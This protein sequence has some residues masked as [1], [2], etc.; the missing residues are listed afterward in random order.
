MANLYS[1][2]VVLC[3]ILFRLYVPSKP[4]G[5][6]LNRPNC[7]SKTMTIPLI[8]Y[9]GGAKSFLQKSQC[10]SVFWIKVLLL[11][12]KTLNKWEIASVDRKFSI[13]LSSCP[14]KYIWITLSLHAPPN[15]FWL[16]LLRMHIQIYL[17]YPSFACASKYENME[18]LATLCPHLLSL[19]KYRPPP[20][21]R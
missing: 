7:S 17:G 10:L 13:L 18:C 1:S 8:L 6:S 19:S 21:L 20:S 14:S 16:H 12:C 9:N 11:T 4:I 5:G 15:I 2:H 3:S